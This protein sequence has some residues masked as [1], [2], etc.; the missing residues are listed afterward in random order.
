MPMK[1]TARHPRLGRTSAVTAA[2]AAY[3]MAQELCIS[4]S[5]LPRC[6]AGQV[7]EMSAAPLAHSPPIP[8]PRQ[9][10]N[11]ASWRTDCAK[12]HAAVNTE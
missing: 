11:T 9:T 3:P 4:P 7:S 5:A 6:S 8:K 12:P 1:N 2:A 10:R